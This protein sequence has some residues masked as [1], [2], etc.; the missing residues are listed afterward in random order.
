MTS[1]SQ[2]IASRMACN[3]NQNPIANQQA[4]R[5][6][7]PN[8]NSLNSVL[9][10]ATLQFRES[11][12]PTNTGKAMDPK[13]A[14]YFEYCDHAHGNDPYKYILDNDK[15]YR[16][17]WYLSFREKK[18]RGGDKQLREQ[19]KTFDT[20]KYDQLISTFMAGGNDSTVESYFPNPTNP[21]SAATFNQ[22]KA[23]IRKIY[24]VQVAKRV[25]GLNWDQIWT[26]SFDELQK[27]VK[28]RMP[29]VRRETYQEKVSGEFAPYTIVGRWTINP[30]V[31]FVCVF[32]IH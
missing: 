24:K 31:L 22:Y 2:V 20:E 13:I 16:F 19:G 15:V 30:V 6:P 5:I 7:H 23:V 14:E 4:T 26:M 18:P 17:M 32:P 10:Q 28:E 12:R 29:A 21:I 25:N 9:E 27:H 1:T 3:N 11:S 8:E